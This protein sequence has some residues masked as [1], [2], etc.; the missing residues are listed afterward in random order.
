MGHLMQSVTPLTTKMNKRSL[1]VHVELLEYQAYGLKA[2]STML[3]EQ[4]TTVPAENVQHYVGK[5]ADQNT[6]AN[7][8]TAMSV[9]F[10]IISLAV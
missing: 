7:I 3:I 1:P 8:R 4:I 5:I 6:L 2:P 9:Q 10:P